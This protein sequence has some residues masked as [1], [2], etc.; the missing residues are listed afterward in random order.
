MFASSEGHGEREMVKGR[1][2]TYEDT[3]G[4]GK[5]TESDEKNLIMQ[6]FVIY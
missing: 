5:S 6:R 4:C 2:C 1:T 3:G